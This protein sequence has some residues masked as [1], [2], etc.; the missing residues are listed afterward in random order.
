VIINV[1]SEDWESLQRGSLTVV[2]LKLI[3]VTV[4]SGTGNCIVSVTSAS[5]QH[6]QDSEKRTLLLSLRKAEA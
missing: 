2:E 1:S 4:I 5:I 6:A 3:C